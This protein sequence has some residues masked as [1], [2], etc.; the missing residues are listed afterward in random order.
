M[1][2]KRFQQQYG[3]QRKLNYQYTSIHQ[4]S[5]WQKVELIAKTPELW[6]RHGSVIC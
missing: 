5:A 3:R 1:F 6:S 4:Y 2:N